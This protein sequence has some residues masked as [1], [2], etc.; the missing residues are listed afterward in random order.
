[1]EE[2]HKLWTEKYRPLTFNEIKGQEQIVERI[3]AMIEQKNLS[4]LIFAGPPGIGKTTLILVAA[5]ELYG[6][7]WKSNVME[8]N[9][10][11]DRGINIIREDIKNFA[12][13]KT[14]GNYPF[15]ICILD[16]ADALTKEA[17][18]ALRRTMEVFSNSCRFCLITNY[19]S[20]IIE[21]IM[22]RC[23]IFRFK[24]LEKK[25]VKEYIEHIA[26][27]E[28]LKIDDKVID[29]LYDIT[30]G[31]IRRAVNILQCC[32]SLN[33]K[34]TED[35]IYNVVSVARPKEIKEVLEMAIKGDFLKARS[36]LLDVMLR[37]GLSGL[38][39][40]KQIQAEI[41]DLKLDDET[42]IKLVD[43]C[44]EIEFRMVE[45]S[46]EYVQLEALLSN[47]IKNERNGN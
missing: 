10:S 13:T 25:Q 29:M 26:K 39:V 41:W 46:D 44:G 32:A 42:K 20:K 38:D 17:Q 5:K 21:P 31:D 40:I 34:I 18:H 6:E 14:M 27:N 47:F 22:S 7:D 2:A 33:K 30:E 1:M 36:M 19:S 4:H 8:T 15:K 23:M 16:E 28:S 3:K 43:K 11:Q 24:P 9:A 37:H 45:G 12:R 35:L